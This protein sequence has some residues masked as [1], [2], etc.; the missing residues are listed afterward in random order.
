MKF[1]ILSRH[2]YELWDDFAEISA[3]GSIFAKTFYLEAIGRPYKIGA[4]LKKDRI[5]GGIVLSK[6]EISLYSNP[7]FAKYLGIL[8]PPMERKYV[9]RLTA[10]KRIIAQIVANLTYTSF[11]YNFHPE[12]TNWLPFYWKGY[13]Q[14]T[15]YTYRIDTLS[16]LDHIYENLHSRVRKNIRKAE[17]NDIR[18]DYD[19]SIDD[20]FRINELTYK[21][22]GGTSPFS[23]KTFERY[24]RNLKKH[25]AINLL[26]AIDKGGRYHAVCGIVHDRRCCYFLFNGS[27]P[28]VKNVEANSLLVIKAIE[29]AAKFSESFDFEG[30]MIQPIERFYR[31]FGALM[32]P[33]MNIWKA[34]LFNST[35]RLM[36]I[37]YKKMRYGQ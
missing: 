19:I 35:K 37:Y 7:M 31:G 22:Q 4:L 8:L 21:R 23:L 28:H 36:F 18:I 26:G 10:E 20:F 6:N 25:G 13:K 12:F 5:Q 33:Y 27:N 14:L 24:H 17:K 29:Y 9:N 16:N 32:T 11:D 1:R 30:S 3:Q 34:N 2:D 15:R